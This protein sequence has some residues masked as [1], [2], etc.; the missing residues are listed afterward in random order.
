MKTI[1][2]VTRKPRTPKHPTLTSDGNEVLA[3]P[4]VRTQ[5]FHEH[6]REVMKKNYQE[7]KAEIL[8]KRKEYY[9]NMPPEE[10]RQLLDKMK[11]KRLAGLIPRFCL[12]T[13]T[14]LRT[15]ALPQLVTQGTPAP[16]TR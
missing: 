6:N 14:Q 1:L 9:K 5:A 11:A 7:N 3:K 13:Q 4:R 2:Q 16:D 12:G 10:K 8:K 15:Q